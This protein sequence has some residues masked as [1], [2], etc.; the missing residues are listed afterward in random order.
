MYI[1]KKLRPRELKSDLPKV[2]EWVSGKEQRIKALEV[3][4]SVFTFK[5]AV[6]PWAGHSTQPF[7]VCF[8][9]CKIRIPT[10]CRVA[11]RIKTYYPLRYNH[12]FTG[13]SEHR[14]LYR[15]NN[16]FTSTN[17]GNNNK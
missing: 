17:K 11:M 15:K 8:L 4:R 9:I 6:R 16:A 13:N 1:S 7:S 3:R 14:K 2:T 10:F 5:V 12:Q